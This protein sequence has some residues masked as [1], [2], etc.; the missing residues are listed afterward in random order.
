MIVVATDEE[1]KLA[2][3]R[4]KGHKII[5]T[6]V[7]GINVIETL[8]HYPKW[9]KIINFG[10]AGSNNIPVGTE[11]SIGFCQSYH[12]NTEYLEPAYIINDKESQ[13]WCYTSKD[14]VLHT[15]VKEPCV[16]DM[17]LAYICALG[18]KNV[19]SI[20][21]ISDNLNMKSYE[22]EIKRNEV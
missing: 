1:Y 5:K 6:G 3:K 8:K 18:F 21:I 11:V 13:I 20:K 9:L 12:P 17:E 4:F 16:F 19:K 14:F 10:Y 2:K 22:N 7:G 15:D